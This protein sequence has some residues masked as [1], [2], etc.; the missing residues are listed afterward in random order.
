MPVWCPYCKRRFG[1][2]RGLQ[3]HI[4][5]DRSC[6]EKGDLARRGVVPTQR[7]AA[8]YL[9]LAPIRDPKRARYDASTVAEPHHLGQ[10]TT[11]E[12]VQPI[13]FDNVVEEDDDSPNDVVNFAHVNGEDEDDPMEGPISII[14]ADFK[15]Y[16]QN[17]RNQCVPF[18]PWFQSTLELMYILRK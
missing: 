5:I 18:R 9:P 7:P 11:Q 12:S 6:R 10:N 8:T 3:Q 1:T 16:V 15:T 13:S 4:R 14:L 17:T 2:N